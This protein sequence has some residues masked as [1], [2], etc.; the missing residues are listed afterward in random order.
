MITAGMMTVIV[1][2]MLLSCSVTGVD[3]ETGGTVQRLMAQQSTLIQPGLSF[4][5]SSNHVGISRV[6]LQVDKHLC[7]T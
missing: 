5:N 2:M 6:T 4:I 7:Y 3:P 1:V